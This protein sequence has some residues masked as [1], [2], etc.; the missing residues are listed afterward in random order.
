M[1]AQR[2]TVG[3][4][5]ASL[6]QRC[7]SRKPSCG[8]RSGCRRTLCAGHGGGRWP[9]GPGHSPQEP[10]ALLVSNRPEWLTTALGCA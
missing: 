8:R 4:L 10:V 3:T 1:L 2:S 5:L 9:L 6:A 7:P